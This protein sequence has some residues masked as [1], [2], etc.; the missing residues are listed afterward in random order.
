MS[1][2]PKNE[3]VSPEAL[4]TAIINSGRL[5]NREQTDRVRELFR[6]HPDVK[7]SP[8]FQKTV[9]LRMQTVLTKALTETATPESTASSKS[10]LILLEEIFKQTFQRDQM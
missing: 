9:A 2:L 7:K 3:E 6:A 5:A 1:E 8:T 10:E 4:L